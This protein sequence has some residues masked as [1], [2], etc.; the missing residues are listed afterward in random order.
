[1]SGRNAYFNWLAQHG[2]KRVYRS[3]WRAWLAILSLW[4]RERKA[5]SLMPYYCTRTDDWRAGRTGV[6]HVHI[7]HSRYSQV[8]RLRHAVNKRVVWPYYRARSR[9]RNARKPVR[10][11]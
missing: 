10:E 7:G 9:W 1:M 11:R 8:A 3:R 6:P 5:D 2:R 4:A